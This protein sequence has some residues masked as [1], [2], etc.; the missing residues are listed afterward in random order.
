MGGTRQS[1]LPSAGP[2]GTRPN[3]IFKNKK[4]IAECLALA[5]DKISF[6]KLKKNCQVPKAYT[7]QKYVFKKKNLP[8]AIR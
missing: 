5:L 3:M 6:K 4:K 7:R 1:A 8:S 2:G